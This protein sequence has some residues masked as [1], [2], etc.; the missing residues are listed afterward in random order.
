MNLILRM[1]G[2]ISLTSMASLY[3]VALPGFTQNEIMHEQTRSFLWGGDVDVH[4]NAPGEDSLKIDKETILCFYALPAGNTIEWTIGK[5]LEEGDDWHY[6]IQHIGAQTRFLRN[7]LK[8]KNFITIYLQPTGTS[9]SGYDDIHPTDYVTL[10]HNMTQDILAL[11]ADFN[12]KVTL[13]SHSAG[14]SW[15]LRNMLGRSEVPEWIDRFGFLDSNYN[16]KYNADHYD[17]LFTKFLL[18]RDSTYICLLAYNDSIAL[19]QGSP[20]VSPEGGTWWNARYMKRRLDDTFTFVDSHDV[21]FQRHIAL[22]KRF[23]ILLKENPTQA[24]LH[25]VQVYKNGFI[26][27]MLSGTD[28]ENV[29]YDYYG[30]PAYLEYIQGNPPARPE[31][32]SVYGTMGA[33]DVMV[34]PVDDATGYRLYVSDD[35]E[36]M[37]DTVTISSNTGT[38]SGLSSYTTYYFKISAVN[39]WGESEKSEWLAASYGDLGSSVLLVNA[40][41]RNYGN[42][43]L[44]RHARAIPDGWAATLGSCTNTV[45]ET[46]GFAYT[47]NIM[48]YVV[49][50][51]D[52]RN[53]TLNQIEISK[54]EDFL[55][56]GGNLF[57]TG[58]EI[59]YDLHMKGDSTKKAFCEDFL[60]MEC[61]SDKPN[62]LSSTYYDAIMVGMDTSFSFQFDDGS[63]GAYNVGDPD[64]ILPV[65]GGYQ[66]AFFP[67]YDRSV[68]G[69]G[70]AYSGTFPGGSRPGRVF[71]MS[72]PFEAIVGDTVRALV[73]SEILEFLTSCGVSIDP[74][75]IPQKTELM[76][77]YPN[78]FNPIAAISCQLS[79]VSELGLSVY[80]MRGQKIHT[81]FNGTKEAGKYTFKWN[82]QD[83]SSGIYVCVMSVNGKV[84]DSVKML[85]VK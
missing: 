23:E 33:I 85:L 76:A 13:N 24:I 68:S 77:P 67:A 3:A 63:Q 5:Q 32:V 57:I 48:D 25:T 54:I 70:V 53:Y 11:F 19:Y 26:H 44:V 80:N 10:I 43:Y 17:S 28:Y 38:L 42:D 75:D 72:V 8:D 74:I 81:L 59:A 35:G 1:I 65:N 20:I 52:R 58:S 16:Y 2:I 61:V 56:T 47:Y 31:G 66:A 62:N 46:D 50:N 30:E 49:G 41:N 79:A 15:I 36:N 71:V 4:I 60:K 83:F 73:M 69:A 39:Q 22:N 9:W 40:V 14:G 64:G 82:A 18:E 12:Y 27:S 45:L 78:P 84:F 21:D 51:E 55:Q 29:G 7:T 6:D 34:L 37:I